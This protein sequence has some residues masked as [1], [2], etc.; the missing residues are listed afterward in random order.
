MLKTITIAG[1]EMRLCSSGATAMIYKSQ[2][3]NDFFSDVI[4]MAKTFDA[5]TTDG[6]AEE[7]NLKDLDP[8]SIDLTVLYNIV[9]ALAK[10]ADSS[11]G[12][13]ISF[14]GQYESLP[15]EEIVP[16]IQDMLDVMFKTSKK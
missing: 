6:K 3:L 8:D 4:R 2:F 12:D 15:L 1:K 11:I 16:V 10:N 5:L 13:P 9:W 14:F 7:L